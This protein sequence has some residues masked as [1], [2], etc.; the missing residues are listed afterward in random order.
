MVTKFSQGYILVS[1]LLI[2]GYLKFYIPDVDEFSGLI[3]K[4]TLLSKFI[5]KIPAF[6][7]MLYSILSLIIQKEKNNFWCL[8]I[9]EKFGNA[10]ANLAV[11]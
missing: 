6:L 2:H 1:I 4:F 5:K 7:V 8:K 9:T 11:K 3:L 10:R